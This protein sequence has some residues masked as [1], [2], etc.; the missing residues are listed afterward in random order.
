MN[1]FDEVEP[2]L[3][4][5]FGVAVGYV[6]GAEPD[7]IDCHLIMELPPPM[8]RVHVRLEPD[9]TATVHDALHQAITMTDEQV[10]EFV[11]HVHAGTEKG[12]P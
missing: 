3:V 11:A 10:R 5:A 8:G 4:P 9:Q 12:Q 1:N 2:M 6:A 7:K